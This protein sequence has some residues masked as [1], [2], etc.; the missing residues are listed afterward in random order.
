MES[1]NCE[2]PRALSHYKTFVPLSRNSNRTVFNGY[3]ILGTT[4]AIR[5]LEIRNDKDSLRITV[6]YCP[7]I[8]GIA[9]GYRG[10]Y[11]PL[12]LLGETVWSFGQ[13][14]AFTMLLSPILELVSNARKPSKTKGL[15]RLQWWLKDA[16]GWKGVT[17]FGKGLLIIGLPKYFVKQYLRFAG[18][19]QGALK[20]GLDAIKYIW[21]GY[22]SLRDGQ[23][24]LTLPNREG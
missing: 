14:F 16:G 24:R 23:R 5:V 21:A 11:A 19:N 2:D 13:I 12:M 15:N 20:E 7:I 6:M 4:S 1:P 17:L 3:L 18:I 22:R 10:L 8:L 9:E